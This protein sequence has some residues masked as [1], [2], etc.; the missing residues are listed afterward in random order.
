LDLKA[1]LAFREYKDLEDSKALKAIP[2]YRDL[3]DL[4]AHKALKAQSVSRERRV[5][6]V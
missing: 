5:L 1:L 6:K 2:D 3:R 4:L